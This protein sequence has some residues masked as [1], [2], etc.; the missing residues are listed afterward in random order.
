MGLSVTCF[1]NCDE[2]IIRLHKQSWKFLQKNMDYSRVYIFR[3]LREPT[4]IKTIAFRHTAIARYTSACFPFWLSVVWV[5]HNKTKINT[6]TG[7]FSWSAFRVN[8]G[9]CGW[10][11][12]GNG[13][14]ERESH[15]HHHYHHHHHHHHHHQLI[16]SISSLSSYSSSSSWPIEIIVV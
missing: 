14:E 3:D 4:C 2:K 16:S 9:V 6:Q 1:G 13:K 12:V 10:T 11:F 15:H 7:L 5:N 8:W